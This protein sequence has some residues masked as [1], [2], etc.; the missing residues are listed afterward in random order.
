MGFVL[1]KLWSRET[2]S[3]KI[4]KIQNKIVSIQNFK[5]DTETRQA[6][7]TKSLNISF[8]VMY[9]LALILGLIYAKFY[10][11]NPQKNMDFV[12][13]FKIFLGFFLAPLTFWILKKIKLKELREKKTEILDQ[14]TEK[15]T[16]KVAREILEKYA[17]ESLSK[18]GMVSGF[19]MTSSSYSIPSSLSSIR[20][21][22][23]SDNSSSVRRRVVPTTAMSVIT[24]STSS[25][26]MSSSRAPLST[27]SSSNYSNRSSITPS[28]IGGGERVPTYQPRPISSYG[29]LI[30]RAPGPRNVR[31]LTRPMLPINRHPRGPPLP[32]PVVPAQK[33]VFGKLMDYVVGEG[34]GNQ[35]ALICKQCQSHNG[36]AQHED[37]DYTSYR[38]C[39]CHYWNPPKK[40]RPIAPKL[41]LPSASSVSSDE[42]DEKVAGSDEKD[43]KKESSEEKDKKIES[44][45]DTDVKI[46]AQEEND[47]KKRKKQ[48]IQKF[49]L[50]KKNDND[51]GESSNL[52]LSGVS[53]E[54]NK[55]DN[56]GTIPEVEGMIFNNPDDDEKSDNESDIDIIGE[57]EV[58]EAKEV[59][60]NSKS[61]IEANQNKFELNNEE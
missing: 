45:E 35:Y 42:K 7:I 38:C 20:S 25:S 37:Y 4:E 24:S 22:Y 11:H 34:P 31:P 9:A 60:E 23:S 14:V 39:Y 5:K 61:N 3:Q 12:F 32:R 13:K 52:K 41:E 15:E 19:R 28:V 50:K 56:E 40:K 29:P 46:E 2:T 18:Y 21:S 8:C 47:K 26:S 44:L 17:P 58:F 48:T 1:S 27:T 55:S 43:N 30:P 36:M 6:K 59:E 57:E 53:L 54:E 16:F 33:S 10:Y 49:F 51:E